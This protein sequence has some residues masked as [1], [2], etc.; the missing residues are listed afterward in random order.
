MKTAIYN[1]TGQKT[2]EIDLLPSL[3]EIPASQALLH[4]VV[5]AAEKNARKPYADTKGRAEVRGGGR[6]PWKQKGTGRARHGS[7]RSPLW[8]GG[9]VTFGPTSERNFS[10]KLNKKMKNKA[11]RMVLSDKAAND[12]LIIVE[13]IEQPIIKTKDLL[14]LLNNLP[15]KNNSAVFGQAKDDKPVLRSAKNLAKVFVT[16]AGS[17][18]VTDLLKHKYLILS[19]TGLAVVQKVFAPKSSDLD[20]PKIVKKTSK[21][22]TK[23]NTKKTS[24]KTPKE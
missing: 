22:T 20:R 23:K 13:K 2:G 7:T 9:G 10:V 4:Q 6:K 5:V 21:K 17:L 11:L 8:R 1:L 3:F 14:N 18:N 15:V 12:L 16:D 19:V 24:K